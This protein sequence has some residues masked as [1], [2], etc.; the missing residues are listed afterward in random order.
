[1]VMRWPSAAL[2]FTT[3][4]HR[5][6]GR[7]R[8]PPILVL[9]VVDLRP[10]QADAGV[11]VVGAGKRHLNVVRLVIEQRLVNVAQCEMSSVVRRPG[12]ASMNC[13]VTGPEY[14]CGLV[15]SW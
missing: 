5:R 13:R 4:S 11:D 7:L 3:L 8:R 6:T 14:T 12:Y 2:L 10:F 15:A 1:M 9:G